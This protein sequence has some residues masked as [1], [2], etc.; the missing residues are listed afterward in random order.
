MSTT[1]EA[2]KKADF[3]KHVEGLRATL[4]FLENL[5]DR[6]TREDPLIMN[7][8]KNKADKPT[9]A[10]ELKSFDYRCRQVLDFMMESMSTTS[11]S[12]LGGKAG[13]ADARYDLKKYYEL[14]AAV[15]KPLDRAIWH[16]ASNQCWDD[17]F[18][19]K[20]GDTESL[21]D[22]LAR[23]VFIAHELDVITPPPPQ[24]MLVHRLA[25]GL[26]PRRY[27]QATRDIVNLSAPCT[28]VDFMHTFVARR[29]T[30]VQGAQHDSSSLAFLAQQEEDEEQCHWA[31]PQRRTGQTA[32]PV[33]NGRPPVA[34][35]ATTK[36]PAKSPCSYCQHFDVGSPREWF[37]TLADCP[38]ADKKPSGANKGPH[39]AHSG[40]SPNYKGNKPWPL[41]KA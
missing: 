8:L 31:G 24:H 9:D 32:A 23:G 21:P 15:H 2:Y 16:Q 13:Y 37:H 4:N 36:Q 39:K 27:G 7:Y 38:H 35:A 1:R 30:P 22:Y 6:I 20:Q 25:L 3:P 28:T 29:E 12:M 34:P 14:F 10:E 19:L 33:Q 5:E 26:D 17:L 11:K 40:T 18:Q 41:P